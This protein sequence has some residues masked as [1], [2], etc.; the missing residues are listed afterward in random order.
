N[1]SP[2]TAVTRTSGP[3]ICAP[4]GTMTRQVTT[5][6][7]CSPGPRTAVSVSDSNTPP[8]KAA[9]IRGSI[10]ASS[11]RLPTGGAIAPT[12]PAQ[13]PPTRP[14]PPQPP[15]PPHTRPPPAIN[16]HPHPPPPTTEPTNRPRIV[17]TANVTAPPTT[18]LPPTTTEPRTDTIT[19]VPSLSTNND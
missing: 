16:P 13:P 5:P 11:T 10:N 2:P 4:A 19:P 6:W 8:I 7:L 9:E 12:V 14:S 3:R 18:A 1:C 15:S 17:G